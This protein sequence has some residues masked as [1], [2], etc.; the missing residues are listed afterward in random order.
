MQEPHSAVITSRRD[1]LQPM[2]GRKRFLRIMKGITPP[3]PDH[4]R[5]AGIQ[6]GLPRALELTEGFETG[7]NPRLEIRGDP[8]EPRR[9][10]TPG[11][12]YESLGDSSPPRRRG[13]AGCRR[14]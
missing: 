2:S 13:E 7:S 5:E 12:F 14:P 1:E 3:V 6:Q 8:F 9:R 10:D 11:K 4:H